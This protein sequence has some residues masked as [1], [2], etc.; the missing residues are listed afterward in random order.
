MRTDES[1][2]RRDERG[3]E[4]ASCGEM[5]SESLT[6]VERRHVTGR[7]FRVSAGTRFVPACGLGLLIAV[8]MGLASGLPVAAEAR[9]NVIVIYADDLDDAEL[10]CYGGP[11][12]TPNIDRLAIGGASFTRFYPSSPVCTPSR[13]SLL[14][15]RY[16][17][18]SP[19]LAH[20]YPV[21]DHALLLWNTPIV[22]GEST[23][24]KLLKQSGYTTGMVGKWHNGLP[25]LTPVDPDSDITDPQIAR[26]VRENY[27]KICRYVRLCGGFDYADGI[28]GDNFRWLPIPTSLQFHNQDWITLKAL[29]FISTNAKNPFFLYIATTIPHYPNPLQS[30]KADPR[31]TP[32][33]LLDA[34]PTVQPPRRDVLRRAEEAGFKADDWRKGSWAGI[35]WLDDGV[36]A[37]LRRLEQLG[38]T[39]NTLVIFASDHASRG[40]MTCYAEAVPCLLR[41]PEVVRAGQKC[42]ELVSNID[43]A[44][45][46]LEACGVSP[47]NVCLDGRSWLPLLKGDGWAWRDTLFLEI[48]YTRGIVTKDWKYIATR[49][50]ARIATTITPDNRREFNQEGARHSIGSKEHVRYHADRDFPGYYDDDQLYELRSDP[51]QQHNL[52]GDPK[53]QNPLNAMKQQ[54][55]KYSRSLPH[56]FGEFAPQTAAH[57][58][59]EPANPDASEDTRKVLKYLY[60]L[61]NHP[62]K[63]LLS[64]HFAGGAIGPGVPDART[65]RYRFGLHEINYLHE[66]S[67]QWVGLIGADYCAGFLEE[68][69]PLETQMYYKDVNRQLIDYWKAGGLVAVTH[70]QFDP[71]ELYRDGGHCFTRMLPDGV[72]PLDISRLY[73]PGHDDYDNFRV[74]LDRWAEGLQE[75]E[76][77]GVVVLWR[78]Y[79][80]ATNSGKWWCRQPPEQ[81]KA[82]YRYTFDYLTHQKGLNNLLWVYD[83]VDSERRDIDM[84]HYPGDE[85]VDIIGVT[86]NWDEG[87]SAQPTHPYPKKVFA[88][89]EFNVPRKDY[90]WLDTPRDYDYRKKLAWLKENLAYASYFMSWDRITGPYGRGTPDSVR[91]LYNDPWIVNR[92]EIEWRNATYR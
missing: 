12:A 86:V 28:Y 24:A 29:E 61:P 26:S 46:V 81:F 47:S 37:I 84:S 64:G 6:T 22:P 52:A 31:A 51:Q 69:E 44:P 7:E 77:H 16:A 39:D 4:N 90:G 35:A 18:R 36:G 82:L 43:V 68:P 10:G 45:T 14:T 83:A 67:G 19:G 60:N 27:D 92:G 2:L 70:H 73:T 11:V 79:N 85:F 62:R 58:P 13:Y 21:T 80:E 49:F 42:D 89:V 78:P 54:L 30:L 63:R 33:G 23:I 41:W 91:A 87:W 74:I 53:Y 5:T 88:C 40:K 32:A 72:P 50:P 20:V 56:A 17:S 71:R 66:V 25:E 8:A 9:P 65:G 59:I 1:D 57:A 55:A 3:R 75:L 48:T 15:G 76:D 34:A 38:L